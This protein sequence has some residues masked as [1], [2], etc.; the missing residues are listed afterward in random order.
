MSALC[1]LCAHAAHASI[2]ALNKQGG[3]QYTLCWIYGRRHT[4]LTWSTLADAT[5]APIVT[6]ICTGPWNVLT[7]LPIKA[8]VNIRHHNRTIHKSATIH[9][10]NTH[11]QTSTTRLHTARAGHRALTQHGAA[12][13]SQFYPT[14]R[15]ESNY[16]RC[17][18]R[19]RRRR[20]IEP[21]ENARIMHGR[22]DR[23]FRMR[24]IMC[25]HVGWVMFYR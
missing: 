14:N 8:T 16:I 24:C 1:E 10:A 5:A 19:R 12:R 11:V 20:P 18:A 17:C 4:Q 25:V 22:N 15:A 6:R 2:V 9:N 13:H 21:P 3:N 23:V 7:D